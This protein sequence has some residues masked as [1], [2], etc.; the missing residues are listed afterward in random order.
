MGGLI[1]AA[2]LCERAPSLAGAVTSGAALAVSDGLSRSRMLAARVLR[3]VA[4]RLALAAGLDPQGLS[5]DS[6][7]VR[8]YVEDPLVFRT[9][10]TSLAVELM[11]A[12]DRTARSAHQVRV[13]MLMLHG[14]D[15]PICPVA[16]TRAFHETLGVEPRRLQTYPGLRHEIFNE[17]AQERVFEDVL[18]WLRETSV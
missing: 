10:T 11:N 9:M 7:V 4:P 14:E 3:R 17:P 8:A 15:D 2:A 12:V 6:E 16:G 18:A 5:T 1:V 13:P